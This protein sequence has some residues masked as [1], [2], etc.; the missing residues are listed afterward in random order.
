MSALLMLATQSS[1]KGWEGERPPVWN[2]HGVPS[3]PPCGHRPSLLLLA[4]LFWHTYC[5]CGGAKLSG[6][7]R[8]ICN[9]SEEVVRRRLPPKCQRITEKI[10]YTLTVCAAPLF[11]CLLLW[12]SLLLMLVLFFSIN[13]LWN[14]QN[15]GILYS[16]WLPSRKCVLKP[17][18]KFSLWWCH[19][20]YMH[21]YMKIYIT[22]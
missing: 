4:G 9:H 19:K 12:N 15:P 5:W 22:S 2:E 17:V 14:P 18:D 10:V 21:F 6:E 1:V 11:S 7:K 13:A 3:V 20:G 8:E 16:L